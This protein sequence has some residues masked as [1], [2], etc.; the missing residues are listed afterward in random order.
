MPPKIAAGA[1]ERRLGNLK[2]KGGKSN[3]PSAKEEQSESKPQEQSED[4]AAGPSKGAALM[5]NWQQANGK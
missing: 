1:I 3:L 4:N 5:R 2:K